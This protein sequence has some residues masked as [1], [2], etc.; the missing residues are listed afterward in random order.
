MQTRGTGAT[1]TLHAR[2]ILGQLLDGPRSYWA[3][4]R[5]S[6]QHAAQFIGELR[7]L[8]AGGLVAYS[9][10]QFHL[11]P[12]GQELARRLGLR[13][14][15]PVRCTSCTGRGI[16]LSP[17]FSSALERFRTIARGRPE[18]LALY[19]QGAVTP[20]V[21]LLRVA[22]MYQQGDLEG[23]DLFLLGDDDLT[24]I[25]AALTELPRRIHV[26]EADER[27]VSFIESVAREQGWE[28]YLTV[29]TYDVRTELPAHLKGRFDVFVTDPV[30]T[31]EGM[32][33]FLSRCTAALRE[34]GAGYFGLSRLEASAQKW[35]E[36]QR[37]LLEM[38]Y[39]ITAVVPEFHEYALDR[40][41]ESGWRVVSE[42]PVPLGPPDVLF[43]TSSLFRVQLVDTPQ[44]L[45]TGP[46]LMGRE[47]YYDDEAYVTSPGV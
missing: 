45:Y 23:R 27:L 33:L 8:L 15:Q 37:G 20:E 47:L 3:L 9:R 13:A 26:V 12:Q 17:T 34:G 19:D 36:I 39:A 16:T 30:E 18:A 24:S 4:L 46:V 21:S 5:G 2:H 42:A 1:V 7:E 35:R 6:R 22:Y 32:L 10:A 29:E 43:Y 28:G 31:L 14:P 25:A 40:V 11:T 44:P 38:G 41:L